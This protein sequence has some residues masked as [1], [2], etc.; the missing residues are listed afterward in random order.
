VVLV[1]GAVRDDQVLQT[2]V[3]DALAAGECSPVAA[4]RARKTSRHHPCGGITDGI[5]W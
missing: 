1:A 4:G 5:R 2:A 3:Q